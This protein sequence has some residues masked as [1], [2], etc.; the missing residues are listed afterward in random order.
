MVGSWISK[1]DT[2]ATIRCQLVPVL[3]S[4]PLTHSL[5]KFDTFRN[6]DCFYEMATES[7]TQM[8]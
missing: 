1:Y 6:K 3:L 4:D 7:L 8:I 5:K 2:K